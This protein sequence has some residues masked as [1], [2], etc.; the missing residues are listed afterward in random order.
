MLDIKVYG[1]TDPGRK[2]TNNEDAFI[3]QQ[4]LDDNHYLAVVIDGVGGHE[5]GE[6][7][8]GI[9]QQTI[10]DYLQQ[11]MNGERLSLLKQA[12]TQAN[13]SIFEARK[14][15][16]D[17]EE[18]SCVITACLFELDDMC[19]NMVHIGDTR[20]YVYENSILRKL[21]HD[22]SFVGYYEE[23]GSLTEEEAMNH[24]H[25]NIINRVVG[26]EIHNIDDDKFIE[27]QTF[28]LTKGNTYLLCSDG[29]YDMLT[30]G[31]IES[32]LGKD[33]PVEEKVNE[34]IDFAN[35]K[36]GKDNITVV[37]VQLEDNEID[38]I[39]TK[40]IDNISGIILPPGVQPV[41]MQTNKRSFILIMAICCLLIGFAGGWLGCRAYNIHTISVNA[42]INSDTLTVQPKNMQENIENNDTL[43]TENHGQ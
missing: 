1:K 20:L 24:P 39:E 2:R 37:L 22:H 32:I 12:V 43:K 38:S 41:Q 13:N 11:Y 42:I 30:S 14:Q 4:I 31:E 17:C 19:L 29:L 40:A 15:R 33:I 26:D 7:A 6:V 8:A 23:N 9:A 3:A 35:Q 27:S 18:M 16:E 25:R 28:S 5:G 21:S 36:G 34:L 10:V